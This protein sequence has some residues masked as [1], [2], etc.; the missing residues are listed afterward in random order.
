[1]PLQVKQMPLMIGLAGPRVRRRL[2]PW[3]SDRCRSWSLKVATRTHW[4]CFARGGWLIMQVWQAGIAVACAGAVGGIP[5]A[6]LSE[7]RGFAL[8]R[9][10]STP[11]GTTI[12]R[13]GFLGHVVVGAIAAFL[14][15]G[16][17]GPLTSAYIMG[18]SG[19]EPGRYEYGLTVAALAGALG[20]G[21]GGARWLANYVDKEVL[22]KAAATAAGKQASQQAKTEI[23][24]AEPTEALVIA[25]SLPS[26]SDVGAQ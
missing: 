20:V 13:P 10:V 11:D 25:E 8:P 14:S 17:Y 1:M 15:W 16:L 24:N 23:A 3:R 12:F 4:M 18:G 9:P 19:S 5:S 26:G 7:D 2:R 21:V 22:Q 6:L